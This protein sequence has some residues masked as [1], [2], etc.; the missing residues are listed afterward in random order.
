MGAGERDWQGASRDFDEVL[1]RRPQC[2]DLHHMP[3]PSFTLQK[4]LAEASSS[5]G[6][7]DEKPAAKRPDV[8]YFDAGTKWLNGRTATALELIGEGSSYLVSHSGP[9]LDALWSACTD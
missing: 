2:A 9:A 6:G 8:L 4:R 7:F 3:G 5:A 1:S